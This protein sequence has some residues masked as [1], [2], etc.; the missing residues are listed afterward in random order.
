[1][2]EEDARQQARAIHGAA[3]EQS[4]AA[5]QAQ[6]NPAIM[7][8]FEEAERKAID[9]LLSVDLAGDETRRLRLITVAATIRKM[10]LFLSQARDAGAFAEDVL[11]RMNEEEAEANGRA[12]RKRPTAAVEPA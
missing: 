7:A 9:A 10:R 3:I 11:K 2:T 6:Q 8:Y 12:N 4:Q 5:L 1:M